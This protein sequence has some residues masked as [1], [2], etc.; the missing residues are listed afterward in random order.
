M[1]HLISPFEVSFIPG[2]IASD[3]VV[4]L[5]EMFLAIKKKKENLELKLDLE[6]TYDKLESDFIC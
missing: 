6:K 4:I 1:H 5:K 2:C 3:N